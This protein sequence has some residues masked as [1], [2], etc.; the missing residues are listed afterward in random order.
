MSELLKLVEGVPETLITLLTEGI[1]VV[2][3]VVI[4]KLTEGVGLTGEGG[5]LALDVVYA[6][7]DGVGLGGTLSLAREGLDGVEL[8][9][10]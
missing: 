1:D 5:K 10:D 9:V 2:N 4:S 8:A 3:G 6:L 7:A